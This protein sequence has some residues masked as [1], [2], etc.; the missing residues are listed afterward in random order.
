MKFL[1]GKKQEMNQIFL[2]NGTAVP[3]TRIKADTCFVSGKKELKESNAHYIQL[4][5]RETK[6]LN[7]PLQGFFKKI[8]NKEIGY[9]TVK[10][11]RLPANDPMFEKLSVGQ[12]LDASI[13]QVGDKVTVSG[14]SKGKGFQGVVKRHGFHGSPASHGHKDQ[15]RMPGSIGAG[16]PQHV[17]KGMRMGGHMGN[18]KITVKNLEIV[19]I[20]LDNNEIFVK[21]AIPGAFNGLL[22]IVAQGE[23]EIKKEEAPKVEES[24]KTEKVPEVV[25]E[26]PKVEEAATV[27]QPAKAEE[28][29]NVQDD[30]K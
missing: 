13:F 24:T 8:F 21:G 6:R 16:E 27:E 19:S 26:A 3:V 2:E 12:K 11:F 23:F 30:K 17:F 5:A 25:S 9:K 20:D 29:S 28:V 7:K 22:F 18:A 14:T 4:A 10:E 15:L 1:I